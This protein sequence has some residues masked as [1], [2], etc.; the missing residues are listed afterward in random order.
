[1]HRSQ[2][3]ALVTAILAAA[4]LS[5]ARADSSEPKPAAGPT[6]SVS[7]AVAPS[8]AP[9]SS[10]AA[11]PASA[12]LAAVAPLSL[13]VGLDRHRTLRLGAVGTSAFDIAT[14]LL[15]GSLYG[16]CLVPEL[17]FETGGPDP[18][19]PLLSVEEIA[20]RGAFRRS[21]GGAP[22]GWA[23]LARAAGFVPVAL[24]R[25]RTGADDGRPRVRMTLSPLGPE[26][27]A[28]LSISGRFL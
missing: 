8:L 17:P 9:G 20:H 27:T 16:A 25:H 2:T 19:D 13:D 12:P 18:R 7:A 11:G 24:G 28:G 14:W 26:R 22:G 23:R 1:M 5:E 15:Y 10:P 3:T 21:G 4:A 6:L